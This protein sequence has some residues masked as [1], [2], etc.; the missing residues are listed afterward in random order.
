LTDAGHSEDE[1]PEEA[2]IARVCRITDI[3]RLSAQGYRIMFEEITIEIAERGF[4][5]NTA[6]RAVRDACVGRG[7]QISRS[8]VNFV[9]TGLTYAGKTPRR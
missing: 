6:A 1:D 3:P 7:E 5:R 2:L 4:S 8:A 9:L